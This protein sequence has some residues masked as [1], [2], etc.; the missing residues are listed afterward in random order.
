MQLLKSRW[1]LFCLALVGVALL[2]LS[3]DGRAE[4]PTEEYLRESEV[5]R[6][7]LEEQVAA[8]CTHVSGVSDV[9]VILTVASG[10]V[11]IYAEDADGRV[12]TAGGEAVLSAYAV[13]E[14]TGVAVVCRGAERDSV[15][16]ELINLLS[17]ALGISSA[18]IYISAAG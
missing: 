10:E 15:K 12:V 13:P 2:I 7:A 9:R 8:L 11:A 1:W 3:G 18:R 6:A 14:V 4:S 5:Y 16:R 17:A